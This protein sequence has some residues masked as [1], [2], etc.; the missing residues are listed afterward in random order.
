MAPGKTLDQAACA[1]ALGGTKY[2]VA[3]FEELK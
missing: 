3:R 2:T 1:K